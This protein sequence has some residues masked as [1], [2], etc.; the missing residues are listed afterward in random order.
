MSK[1]SLIIHGGCGG[2]DKFSEDEQQAYLESQRRILAE[3]EALLKS[4]KS[5]LETVEYCVKLLEDDTLYNAGK[6]SV[7]NEDGEVEMDASIMDGKDLMAG[8]VAGIKNIKNPVELA[9]KVM[10]E[11]P[12]VFLI[13]DGAEK[14]AKIHNI[15]TENP[16]YFIIEKRKQQL[17][18]AKKVGGVMLDYTDVKLDN[19]LGTVGAVARDKNGNLA[20]ATSTGGMTNKKFGRVGDSPLIGAGNYADNESCGISCTGK[21]EHFIKTGFAKFVSD[22]IYLKNLSGPEA[23]VEAINYFK[24]KMNGEGGFIMIDKD[25]NCSSLFTTAGL[26]RAWVSEGE[27][28]QAKLFN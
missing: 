23:G 6:G 14:F 1:Y 15:K 26:I 22:L 21:G 17:E 28:I 5:A 12:H 7:L 4:G 27:E 3:G 2:V 11:T 10:E 18:L 24:K 9:K 20:A 13:G 19:K 16:E 25:G 8:A